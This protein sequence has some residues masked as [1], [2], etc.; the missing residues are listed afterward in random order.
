MKG[1]FF[2]IFV[3]VA[4][5]FSML[6]VPTG[7]VAAS[8][9]SDDSNPPQTERG[10]ARL[11]K[12]YQAQLIA[13]DAQ[14]KN[15]VRADQATVRVTELIAK[16]KER[17]L[18]TTPL[19]QALA[20]YQAEMVL[21]HQ[22]HDTAAAILGTH[23]G[24]DDNGKVTDIQAARE[25]VKQAGQSL[26]EARQTMRQAAVDLRQAIREFREANQPDNTVQ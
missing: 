21:A 16:L 22:A 14:T 6:F 15:L 18:D 1:K 23:A 19:E 9:L 2:S 11:E 26:R 3:L 20:T 8:G 12:L 25:T 13:L 5:V 24:F 7:T 4:V 17:G 10:A